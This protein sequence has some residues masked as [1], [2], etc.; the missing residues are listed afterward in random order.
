M[1]RHLKKHGGEVEESL[2]AIPAGRSTR[3]SLAQIGDPG[4][5]ASLA[6]VGSGSTE[7]DGDSDRT[8]SYAVGTATRGSWPDCCENTRQGVS[9]THRHLEFP[10]R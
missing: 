2:A 5:E 1:A 9:P 4:I 3:E 7:P 8:A 10:G 6:H